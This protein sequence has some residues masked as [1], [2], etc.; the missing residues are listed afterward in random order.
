MRDLTI[1]GFFLLLSLFSFAQTIDK[2]LDEGYHRHKGFF[3]SMSAGPNFAGITDVSSGN[4][5]YKFTGTGGQ[6]DLKIGGAIKENLILHATLTSNSLPG[7][8]ITSY[9]STGKA[10]N[11]LTIGEAMIGGG[12]TYYIMP[13]NIFLSGS[14]GIGDFTLVDTKGDINGTTERGVS[15]QLKVGKEWW[16]SRKWGL[17][18]A[19][20]YGKTTLTNGT[21]SSLEE[22]LNSSNIG[23]LFNATLN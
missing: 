2:T 6:F 1:L 5:D 20:T 22:Q 11:N 19:L 10:N 18:V 3:L 12:I 7:P 15:M 9:G 23:I 8:I 13:V 14:L 4:F 21:G 17:G 16:V